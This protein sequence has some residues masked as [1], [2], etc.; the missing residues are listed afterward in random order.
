M[1]LHFF[2]FFFFLANPEIFWTIGTNRY[3]KARFYYMFQ[4]EVQEHDRDLEK[5]YNEDLNT[6]LIFV[7]IALLRQD[8]V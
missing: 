2:F 3:Q 4:R 1:K 7:S 5:K 8:W 6:T